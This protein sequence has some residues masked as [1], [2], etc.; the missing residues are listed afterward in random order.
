MK[1]YNERNKEML[2]IELPFQYFRKKEIYDELSKT[3]N[4]TAIKF[5][6]YEYPFSSESYLAQLSFF[7]KDRSIG[8]TLYKKAKVSI[9]LKLSQDSNNEIK[10]IQNAFDDSI[11]DCFRKNDFEYTSILRNKNFLEVKSNLYFEFFV[12]YSKEI[13]EK[14]F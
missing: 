13:Y 2:Q 9:Y 11:K 5:D 4:I 6:N 1:N 3:A 14:V 10:K 7:F 12:P 8:F